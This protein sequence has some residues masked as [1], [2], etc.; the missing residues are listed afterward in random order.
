M[1]FGESLYQRSVPRWAAYNVKYNELKH[2]I[3]QRTSGGA[4]IPLD[5]PS[6]GTPRWQTLEDDLFHIIQD[7]HNNVSLFLRSKQGEIERRLI[8]LDKQ[9]QAS[10]KAAKNG[11]L[12]RPIQQ[13][14]KYQRLVKDA[15]GIGEEIDLLSRFAGVQKTAFRKIL[16]KYR[17]WTG[18]TSLQARLNVEVFASG[19]LQFDYVEYRNRLATLT[20][21]INDL[22]G[23]MLMG[24]QKTGTADSRRSSSLTLNRSNAKDIVS[25]IEKGQLEL[26]AALETVPYGETAGSRYYWIHPDNLEEAESLLLRHMRTF[27]QST[28]TPQVLPLTNGITTTSTKTHL[29]L[30]D[31][32]QRLIQDT[33]VLRPSNVAVTARWTESPE[34][35]VTLRSMDPKS[36]D[37]NSIT[38]KRKDI[39]IAMQRLVEAGGS[40][41][42]RA[43]QYNQIRSYLS[44]HRD[45]KPL[46]EVHSTRSRYIGSTNS[47]EV[48]TWAILDNAVSFT[49]VDPL[50]LGA[51]DPKPKGTEPFPHAIL[52][53]RWEF[54]RMPEVVRLF[55]TS[56]LAER[57]DNFSLEKAALYTVHKDLSQPKWRQLLDT[58][59][60]RVPM[61]LRPNRL[62]TRDI[63][64]IANSSGPSSTEGMTDKVFSSDGGGKG[65]SSATSVEQS[66]LTS[67]Q[68]LTSSP[69]KPAATSNSKPKPKK[70]RARVVAPSSPVRA[71]PQQRY[72]NEFDDGD[73]DINPEESY[74]IYIDPNEPSFPGAETMSR[75]FG[76]MYQ[77]LSRGKR[78]VVS[79][80][81]ISS[82][83]DADADGTR[84]PLLFDRQ[85]RQNST[86]ADLDSSGSETDMFVTH[87]V[88][89]TKSRTYSGVFPTRYRSGQPLSRRQKALERTLFQFY[90]GLIA[91]SYVLLVM[92]GILE[93]SG[94]KKKV[95][96]VDAGVVAGVAVAEAC[97]TISVVLICMR[98]QSL[99][100]L[101][102]GFLLVNITIVVIIGIA[103]LAMMF[104]PRN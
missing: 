51:M 78:N 71:R 99:G 65:Q 73:S 81:P 87:T 80:L 27:K 3:K 30:Y 12:N 102:W 85:S 16:K 15:E 26:D 74:A 39:G 64:S 83:A 22:A 42:P 13:A 56:H 96:E 94:R 36:N 25:A 72:W 98:R 60:R 33:S 28:S 8:H 41:T 82:K 69:T 58:D 48:G 63:N 68:D 76:S 4:A 17:K 53:I 66:P 44:E 90:T 24:F 70:K 86:D 45:V 38:V 9:V 52:H 14:R 62:R 57:V 47:S 55:D 49:T 18:S 31:N 100:A 95:L 50:Q 23:P 7:E 10:R 34:G 77:S 37:V 32:V 79:W 1:K 103:I 6:A 61:A 101:H 67:Q 35:L 29:V 21:T 43:K 20:Q 93:S 46:A 2:L 59:I 54:S 92:A 91:I 104:A 88:R 75:M 89:R 5:I 97:A 11:A 40:S 84:T 19:A